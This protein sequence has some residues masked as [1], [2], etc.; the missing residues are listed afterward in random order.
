VYQGY[1]GGLDVEEI[2]SVG[3]VAT[4]GLAPSLVIVL[5]MPPAAAADRIRRELDRMEQQGDEF[6]RR[7]REGYLAEAA[8]DPEHIAVVDAA[9]TTDEVQSEIRSLVEKLL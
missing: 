8:R 9:R 7:L 4:G 6:R 3:A 1:A 2:R 5:D